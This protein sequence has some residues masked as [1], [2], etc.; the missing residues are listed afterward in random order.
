MVIREAHG[1][2]LTADVEAL[3]NTVNTV[4]AMGKGLALQ[5]RRAYPQMFEDYRRAAT[6]G[7]LRT[8]RM[9]VW[10]TFGDDGPRF[11]INSPTKRHWRDDSELEYV[12]SG[13]EDLSRVITERRIRSIAVPALGCGLGGLDWALVRPAIVRALAVLDTDVWLYPPA[14]APRVGDRSGRRRGAGHPPVAQ[15]PASARYRGRKE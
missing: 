12:T 7:D 9:H 5:F 11:I 8:G 14:D 6:A 15:R 4:G 1:N 10:E 13:L 2:L 3:V